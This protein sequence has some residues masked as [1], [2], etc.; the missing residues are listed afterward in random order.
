M[1]I[2]PFKACPM[3][4]NKNKNNSSGNNFKINVLNQDT[5][6]FKGLS[7]KEVTDLTAKALKK[8]NILEAHEFLLKASRRS[9]FQSHKEHIETLLAKLSVPFNKMVLE[10]MLG[11]GTIN[12]EKDV[13]PK[14]KSYLTPDLSG[15]DA[16]TK[17]V[18]ESVQDLS[19][20]D[21]AKSLPKHRDLFDI[22]VHNCMIH[23]T[24]FTTFEGVDIL[25]QK[26]ANRTFDGLTE[27]E[28]DERFRA[29]IQRLIDLH[30]IN[31]NTLVIMDTGSNPALVY[32][33]LQEKNKDILGNV[34]GVFHLS[35]DLFPVD[36]KAGNILVD[37]LQGNEDKLP[38][39]SK[40]I[41]EIKSILHKYTCTPEKKNELEGYILN[42]ERRISENADLAHTYGEYV[43]DKQHNS[44]AGEGARYIG[45]E[46]HRLKNVDQSKLPTIQQIKE[47]GIKRVVFLDE[48]LPH[49]FSSDE[50]EGLYTPLSIQTVGKAAGLAAKIIARS[51]SVN[52]GS[53]Q[54]L[55]ETT[56]RNLQS[57]E[58]MRETIHI[59]KIFEKI[60]P[61]SQ[62][63]I[64]SAEEQLDKG[65][66]GYTA[67]GVNHGDMQDYLKKLET[68]ASEHNIQIVREG[69][70]LRMLEL[71]DYSLLKEG[72]DRII[73]SHRE[74]LNDSN[75]FVKD[76]E[77]IKK[78]ADIT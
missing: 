43:H 14:L 52:I 59:G 20:L 70:D 6:S 22:L 36:G 12:M 60:K 54:E 73:S 64:N 39:D 30:V 27:Y 40:R 48:S 18:L 19:L 63:D 32:Q 25:S 11:I 9:E 42:N 77:R 23:P 4:T 15:V 7:V 3:F 62:K 50:I 33:M 29:G 2:S 13:I 57:I 31:K 45:F 67:E 1:L 51:N 72:N 24:L 44:P 34:Q 66:F 46:F 38:V 37:F 26:I 35:K 68:S 58:D 78:L 10:N 61:V 74:K 5:F 16:S 55:H 71:Y 28:Y 49:T 21:A 8:G 53:P 65:I 17:H 56:E 47:M 41:G 76:L 69:I 75:D